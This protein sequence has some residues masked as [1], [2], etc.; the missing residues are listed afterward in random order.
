MTGET[1]RR[2]SHRIIISLFACIIALVS[3]TGAEASPRM[4]R[5]AQVSIPAP[6]LNTPDFDQVFGGRDGKTLASDS[7]G[8]IRALEF[9][10][11]P[12][13]VF[14]VLSATRKG[15]RIIFRV[16]SADYPV[17]AGKGL[18]IDSRFAEILHIRPP[19]RTKSLP[20]L[21]KIIER[22]LAAQG[23][24]Y[25]WGGNVSKG[26]PQIL[27]FYPP[28]EVPTDREYLSRW[29]LAGVD[30]SGLLYEAT[31]GWTPRNTSQ[32][33]NYGIPVKISGLS[34]EEIANRLKPLDLIVWSGHVMIVL[35]QEKVIESRP[36][37]HGETNG[38]RLSPLVETLRTLMKSRVPLDTPPFNYRQANR[39]FVIRRWYQP[40]Q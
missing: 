10:A 20:P 34:P 3:A 9:I 18:Y 19:D 25:L 11:L 40:E 22:L 16:V 23:T 17:P 33:I 28:S 4:A 15:T 6:V 5:F 29:M 7:C 26:V 31:G 35:D 36:G 32:L 38:V 13:T 24:P 2:I 39:S 27:L 12:G 30:C 1:P 14:E 37:C 21:E 8:Q